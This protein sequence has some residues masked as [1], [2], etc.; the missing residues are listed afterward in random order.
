[1]FGTGFPPSSESLG[2]PTY[3]LQLT[4]SSCDHLKK[5]QQL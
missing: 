4:S 1:M 5:K 2:N 3:S